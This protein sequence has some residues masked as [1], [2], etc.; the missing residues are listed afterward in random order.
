M[1]G[2]NLSNITDRISQVINDNVSLSSVFGKNDAAVLEFF[3]SLSNGETIL[4]K[5]LNSNENSFQIS[6]GNGSNVIINAKA[7]A[8]V[9]LTEGTNVLFEV[10]K[11]S[12]GKFSLRPL[13]QNTSSEET[14]RMA[15]RQAGIPS[16]ERTLEMTVRNMEY[17]NP[18]DR[19]SL[20]NSYKDVLNY[21]NA[22][23]KYIVDLQK[24]NIPVTNANLYQYEEYMNMKNI[25]SDSFMDVSDSLL[26]EINNSL[27][28]GIA[29]NDLSISDIIN[30]EAVMNAKGLINSVISFSEDMS[31]NNQDSFVSLHEFDVMKMANELKAYGFSS[32][33]IENLLNNKPKFGIGNEENGNLI[34]PKTVLNSVFRDINDSVNRQI[35]DILSQKQDNNV[36]QYKPLLLSSE[37][38]N[39]LIKSLSNDWL[40][41]GKEKGNNEE[42][43]IN[44]L[45]KKL[46]DGV[47]GLS[48]NLSLHLKQDSPALNLL[49]NINNNVDFMDQLNKYIPYVQIPFNSN[50]NNKAELYVYHNK[51]NFAKDGGEL[52]AYLHL[53]MEH[54]GRTDVMIK[55][56]DGNV[57]TNFKM[58]S[59]EALALVEENIGLL[60]KRLT[61]KGYSLRT[62][63]EVINKMPS[64]I[65]EMLNNNEGHL[66]IAKT[67]FDARI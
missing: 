63:M 8:G 37:L 55:M 20:L 28:Q 13:Y 16:N 4:G 58:S 47:K 59:D 23:V 40:S 43:S 27:Q 45:Y 64:P 17:G 1:A 35:S 36:P 42:N 65:Q 3:N 29:N 22:P 61:E 56:L 21:E 38:K 6:T 12:D 2:F 14:A 25:I 57:T 51:K 48:E 44:S 32:N 52:S 30:N 50:L 60:N 11:F 26:G 46:Y 19:N 62:Q 67:S 24:M 39:I 66:V 15:L 54:L 49:N 53:D 9:L 33:N 18:I 31:L 10:N 5:V 34:N 7:D 41:G